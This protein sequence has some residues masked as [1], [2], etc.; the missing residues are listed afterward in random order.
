M[1]SIK[2]YSARECNKLLKRKGTFWQVESYDRLIRDAD[3]L[4][5]AVEYTLDNPVKAGLCQNRADWKWSYINVDY[6]EF[7]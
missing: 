3:E 5:K 4:Y 2:Q 7:M 1:K 6:N